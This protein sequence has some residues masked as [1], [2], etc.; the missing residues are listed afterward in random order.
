[1]HYYAHPSVVIAR[2]SF[3]P[4]AR[5]EL[6]LTSRTLSAGF[7]SIGYE[8]GWR[9][10]GA[11]ATVGCVVPCACQPLVCDGFNRRKFAGIPVERN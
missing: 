7:L 11:R 8:R 2:C 4:G 6:R 1:M 5:A 3:Q 9:N 10:I